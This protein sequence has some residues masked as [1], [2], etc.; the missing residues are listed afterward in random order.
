M[1][2]SSLT[3]EFKWPSFETEIIWMNS[4]TYRSRLKKRSV[5]QISFRTQGPNVRQAQSGICVK[6]YSW[7]TI[8]CFQNP[9]IRSIYRT[10]PQSVPFLRPNPSIRKPIHPPRLVKNGWFRGSSRANLAGKRFP[11]F[12]Q[13]WGKFSMKLDALIAF[14]QTSYRNMKLYRL[15]VSLLNT[16]KRNKRIR[17]LKTYL[18]F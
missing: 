18:L 7:S 10:N 4:L 8:Q 2:P 6:N 9:R 3:P 17:I 16:T 15:Q 12:A 1:N 14:T 5:I 13:I 11:V